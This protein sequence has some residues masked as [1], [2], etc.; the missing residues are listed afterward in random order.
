[1]NLPPASDPPDASDVPEGTLGRTKSG[2]PM[3]GQPAGGE[4]GAATAAMPIRSGIRSFLAVPGTAMLIPV[5]LLFLGFLG[6]AAVAN[7]WSE[8][9]VPALLAVAALLPSSLERAIEARFPAWLHGCYLGFLLAGPFAGTRLGLYAFRPDWDKV[10]HLFSG[11]LVGC[12]ITFAL[13]IVGRRKHL[14]LPPFLV[15]AGVVTSGGFMAAAWE[16]AEFAS[17]HLLGTHAQN[18][19]LQDT[20]TDIIC[21]VLGAI[22]VAVAVGI[23][24]RGHPVAPVSSLLRNRDFIPAAPRR[25]H[26]A[27][28]ATPGSIRVGRSAPVVMP[29]QLD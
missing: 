28:P 11:L 18:A 13:G 21:G 9:V 24:L 6:T 26:R 29:E 15:V 22:A 19:S 8:A 5:E 14:D 27:S 20:M 12:A 1:M 17:D 4:G 3:V 7:A 25:G 10:I 2:A 23:H 16:I